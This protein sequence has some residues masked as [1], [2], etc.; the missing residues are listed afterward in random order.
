MDTEVIDI[1]FWDILEN[2]LGSS[3]PHDKLFLKEILMEKATNTGH[4]AQDK[5]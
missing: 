1:L 4:V 3:L 5:T 2:I